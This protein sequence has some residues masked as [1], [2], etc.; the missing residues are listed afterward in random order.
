MLY[1]THPFDTF[2][3]P[4]RSFW[5]TCPNGWVEALICVLSA[6]VDHSPQE[7]FVRHP[8]VDRQHLLNYFSWQG[9]VRGVILMAAR[10]L[11]PCKCLLVEALAV[12]HFWTP[13]MLWNGI[14]WHGVKQWCPHCWSHLVDA[15]DVIQDGTS[16][17]ILQAVALV[18]CQPA[19][20][21]ASQPLFLCQLPQCSARTLVHMVHTLRLVDDLL[22]IWGNVTHSFVWGRVTVTQHLHIA[23]TELFHWALPHGLCC[24]LLHGLAGLMVAPSL[25][26]ASSASGRFFASCSL[27]AWQYFDR[28]T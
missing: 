28:T 2:H 6:Y 3:P 25:H 4:K 27:Q 1:A 24:L 20:S 15:W 22:T 7:I 10:L 13:L 8:P 14:S 17:E 11:S 12:Y 19:N 16:L 21:S 5:T 26:A 18:F 23:K 9:C